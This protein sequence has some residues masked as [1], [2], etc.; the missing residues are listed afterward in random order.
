MELPILPI[1]FINFITPS[2]L[3]TVYT[4]SHP[5]NYPVH[6]LPI[7]PISPPPLVLPPLSPTFLLPTH[8]PTLPHPHALSLL[9]DT[10][11]VSP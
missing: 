8:P 7:L 9:S 2:Y 5:L 10:G 11:G 1:H 3:H 6:L 4:D